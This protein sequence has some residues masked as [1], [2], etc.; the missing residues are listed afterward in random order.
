LRYWVALQSD[1][2]E[3][4]IC[5][6]VVWKDILLLH[7]V[8]TRPGGWIRFLNL[9]PYT[10]VGMH[11]DAR[12]G[13][14]V[15]FLALVDLWKSQKQECKAEFRSVGAINESMISAKHVW[16]LLTRLALLTP[17]IMLVHGYLMNQTL[18]KRFVPWH[19][20][21]HRPSVPLTTP[22]NSWTN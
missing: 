19:G 6:F 16:T 5:G 12:R 2:W 8:D 20:I 17:L 10:E 14:I 4:T 11:D 18:R 22:A 1:D 13:I 9:L 15:W 21:T 3:F 7:T